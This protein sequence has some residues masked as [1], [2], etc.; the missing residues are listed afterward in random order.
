LGRVLLLWHERIIYD[1]CNNAYLRNP[2]M[3]KFRLLIILILIIGALSV[4]FLASYFRFGNGNVNDF[5]LLVNGLVQNPL[6]LNFSELNAMPRTT[7]YAVLYCVDYPN[8]PISQGNWTG[9]K[10]NLLLEQAEISQDT[11][12]VAFTATDGYTTDLTVQTAMRQDVIIAYELNGQPLPEKLRLVV[13]GKWGYKWMS[14]V[15]HIELVNFDFKGLW[16]SRGY[17]DEADISSTP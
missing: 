17:S 12:K 3:S 6:N 4:G 7:V 1:V 15:S 2:I 9:V 8:N 14:S 5:N 10:L 11:V 16:E 13:P